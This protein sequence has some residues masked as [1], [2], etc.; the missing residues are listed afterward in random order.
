MSLNK[1]L[2]LNLYN[3]KT[4]SK[5]Y[6]IQESKLDTINNNIQEIIDNCFIQTATWSLPTWET[7]YGIDIQEDDSYEIRRSRVLAKMRSNGLVTKDMIKNLAESFSNGTVEVIEDPANYQFTIRFISTL[8]V[9]TKIQDLYN[10]ISE[11]KPAHLSV[12]Y[13]F[14]YKLWSNIKNYEWGDLSAYSW[15]QILNQ[16]IQSNIKLLYSQQSNGTYSKMEFRVETV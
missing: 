15:S 8:G 2:P 16:D 10:A 14:T 7:E 12:N 9:P 6:K 13:E 11:I 1:Y 3:E 5:V 4:L